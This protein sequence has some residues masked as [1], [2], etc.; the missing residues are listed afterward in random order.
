M[1]PTACGPTM[2]GARSV[3]QHRMRVCLTSGGRPRS[4]TTSSSSGRS[5]CASKRCRTEGGSRPTSFRTSSASEA[6]AAPLAAPLAAAAAA[7]RELPPPASSGRPGVRAVNSPLEA[8]TGGRC[9]RRSGSGGEGWTL[10]VAAAGRCHLPLLACPALCN[11]GLRDAMRLVWSYRE[12]GLL[13]SRPAF[14]KRCPGRQMALFTTL[15]MQN[16]VRLRHQPWCRSTGR[17]RAA[18]PAAAA[19]RPAALRCSAP[20]PATPRM[21]Q[22]R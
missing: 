10:L 18:P 4:M 15:V 17:S 20:E 7:W 5:G 2:A 1:V 19:P 13:R 3:A 9:G 21:P 6:A 8:A 16:A 12:A 14:H 22:S 11:A